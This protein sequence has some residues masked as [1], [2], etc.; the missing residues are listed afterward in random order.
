MGFVT[1]LSS[2]SRFLGSRMRAELTLK[3]NPIDPWRKTKKT[4]I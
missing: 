2:K 3:K 1:V 4:P